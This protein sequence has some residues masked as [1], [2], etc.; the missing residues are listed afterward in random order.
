MLALAPPRGRLSDPEELRPFLPERPLDGHKGTFGHVLLAGGARGKTGA[1]VLAARG[2]A[3]SGA[4][5]VLWAELYPG[6]PGG[7]RPDPVPEGGVMEGF[8]RNLRQNLPG[9]FPGGGTGREQLFRGRAFFD[10]LRFRPLR[11][12]CSRQYPLKGGHKRPV[13]FGTGGRRFF[14]DYL[15][16]YLFMFRGRS[17]FRRIPGRRLLGSSGLSLSGNRPFGDSLGFRLLSGGFTA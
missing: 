13:L 12:T 7:V 2:A 8:L 9:V 6:F 16:W 15:F 10:R 4:A 14:G 3:R 17:N 1:L 11:G 5:L